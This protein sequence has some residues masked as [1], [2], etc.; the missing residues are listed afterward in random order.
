MNLS[1]VDRLELKSLIDRSQPLPERYRWLLFQEPRETEF[2]WP[3]KTHEVTSVVLP[4]QSIEQ[5]DEPRTEAIGHVG[6]F[7][8]LDL[9]LEGNP[10]GGLIS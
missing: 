4:C 8:D 5:I 6:S 2:L 9:L 1:D 3:G 7:F 10:E